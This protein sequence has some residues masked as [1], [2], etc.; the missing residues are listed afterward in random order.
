MQDMS[1]VPG[2]KVTGDVPQT[3]IAM[4]TDQ[5]LRDPW[6]KDASIPLPPRCILG[7]KLLPGVYIKIL[8]HAMP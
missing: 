7:Y 3:K 8:C 5:T 2:V 4:I 6:R 1:E